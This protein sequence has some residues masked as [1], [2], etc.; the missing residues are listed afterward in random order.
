MK[1][2][3]LCADDFGGGLAVN[4][5]I[6]ALAR[7]GRLGGVSCQVEAP[8]FATDAAALAA[9][10][11]RVDLGLHLDLAPGRGGLVPLLVRTHARALSRRAVG[12]RIARQLDRFEA[13]FGRAPD[14][15]DGHQHV[16]A[17]P[18]IR[19]ALLDALATRY[20]APGPVVRNTVP[21]RSRGAKAA[22]VALLGGAGLRRALRARG[23]PHNADFAGV[24]AFGGG[25]YPTRFRAWLAGAADGTLVMCHP[26]L[27]PGDP[28]DPIAA[29]RAAEL[30]YLS[31]AALPA[32]CAAAGASCVRVSAIAVRALPRPRE[33]GERSQRDRRGT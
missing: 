26:G 25:S 29:A 16:H 14:F 10:S 1:R 30:A 20:P 15:V 32:D 28:G 8:R 17:L 3:A 24:Y 23:V 33:A 9:L 22:I 12:A 13:A 5:A 11:D 18:V 19:D 27:A 6:L 21:L 7:A 2:I 31:S 4:A